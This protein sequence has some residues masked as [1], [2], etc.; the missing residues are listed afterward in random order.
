[1]TWARQFPFLQNA[2]PRTQLTSGCDVPTKGLA[3]LVCPCLPHPPP[4]LSVCP[5]EPGLRL[6][7]TDGP[8][9]RGLSVCRASLSAESPALAPQGEKPLPTT[10]TA[11][12]KAQGSQGKPQPL[13][14]PRPSQSLPVRVCTHGLAH[15]SLTRSQGHT[16][17]LGDTQH[18]S[19]SAPR[20]RREQMQ[21]LGAERHQGVS[22][23]HPQRTGHPRGK[24]KLS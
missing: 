10:P 2:E 24:G 15:H 7:V 4:G 22:A 16:A 11:G 1:M 19:H 9:L 23:G 3:W 20:L 5:R 6:E 21:S 8:G 12:C 14:G 18:G 17:A 13:P